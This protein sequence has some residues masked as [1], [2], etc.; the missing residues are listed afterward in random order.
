MRELA[1]LKILKTRDSI[2]QDVQRFEVPR[3]ILVEVTEPPQTKYYIVAEDLMEQIND[4]NKIR[5]IIFYDLPT[6]T[7]YKKKV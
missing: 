6:N 7:Q 3:I 2:S 4:G 5:D 1:V